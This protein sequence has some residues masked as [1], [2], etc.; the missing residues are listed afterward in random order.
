M[1]TN[2]PYWQNKNENKQKAQAH[3]LHTKNYPVGESLIFQSAECEKLGGKGTVISPN[4]NGQDKEMIMTKLSDTDTVSALFEEQQHTIGR[5]CALNFASYKEPGRGFL[6]GSMAQE[7]CLC[8]ASN[9]YHVLSA[10]KE[11]YEWNRDHLN[12]AMYM[13][14][15]IYSKD[16]VFTSK[17]GR[18]MQAD[19]LTCAAPN[20]S[21]KK[22]GHCLVTDEE[23]HK[24]LESRIR[25]ICAILKEMKVS[26]AILGA[27]GCGVFRQDA[28]EV[29]GLFNEYAR[30]IPKV[31]Y[32]VPKKPHRENYDAFVDVIHLQKG[33]VSEEE[34][35]QRKNAH[36]TAARMKIL[37]LYSGGNI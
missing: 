18:I 27:F 6:S 21:V 14:R 11:Y 22:A 32:A 8:H 2:T 9:L 12:R 17:D 34:Y 25:F 15:A 3:L 31:C 7:E 26:V 30:E 28:E 20:K 13:D 29:A 37:T 35:L 1:I 23:N 33:T 36:E 5:I 24:V 4:E 10:Q 19:V 16:V